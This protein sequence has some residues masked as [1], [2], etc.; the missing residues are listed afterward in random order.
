MDLLKEVI[1]ENVAYVNQCYLSA[2]PTLPDLQG[3]LVTQFEILK[4]GQIQDVKILNSTLQNE[5]VETCMKNQLIQFQFPKVPIDKV[6]LK[7][8]FSFF[9]PQKKTYIFTE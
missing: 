4:S 3:D 2:L 9:P 8:T 6:A 5:P 1:Q 7:Y